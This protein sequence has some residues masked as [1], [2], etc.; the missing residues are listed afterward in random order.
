MFL[1]IQIELLIYEQLATSITICTNCTFRDHATYE[2]A[3][4]SPQSLSDAEMAMVSSGL[5]LTLSNRKSSKL[6]LHRVATDDFV[7]FARDFCGDRR[8]GRL[9]LSPWLP[10]GSACLR[11]WGKLA[12]KPPK[13]SRLLELVL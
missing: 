3:T 9:V 8:A 12:R 11:G 4:G 2:T 5:C 7:A 10:A 6:D 1:H 13:N